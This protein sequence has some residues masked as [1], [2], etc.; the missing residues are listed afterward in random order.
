MSG[1]EVIGSISAVITL[2]EASIKIYDSAQNDIKL[3]KTFKVVGRRLPVILHILQ[4][5]KK[6]L[7]PGNDS[8]PPDVCNALDDILAACDEKAKKL[9]E[10]FEKVIPGEKDAWDK[11][12]AKVF[13]RVGKGNEVEEL[14]STLTEDVQLI[15]NNHALTLFM[16]TPE[17]KEDFSFHGP[18]G[19]CLGQAPY[20]TAEH[21]VGRRHELDEIAKVLSPKYKPQKQQRVI[22]GGMG[23]V[24]KTQLAIAYAESRPGSYSSVFWLDAASEAA[25]KD[26]FRSLAN[27]IFDIRNLDVLEDKEIVRRIHKWLSDPNNTGW[28]LIFD[29]YDEPSLFEIEK[30]YPPTSHGAIVVTTRRPDI[31][32]GSTLHIKPFQKIEDSLAILQTRSKRENVQLDPHAKRLAE[33]L[34]GLPLAL[35]TVGTFLRR[36]TFTFERYLQEYENDWNVDPHRPIKLQDY[37]ER[38]LYT[39]WNLSYA[40]LKIDDP[41]AAKLP[42]LLAYFGNQSF[43]YELFHAGITATSPEWLRELVTDYTDFDGAMR[44]LTEY[45]FLDFHQT[46][47]SWNMHNCVHDWTLA[48]LNEEID[49]ENY[50]YAFDCV[51][52]V[53]NGASRDALRH[54]SYSRLAR[55]AAQLVQQ[56]FLQCD[57]I[58]TSAP[59]QFEKVSRVSRLLQEQFQLVSAKQILYKRLGEL[60]KA[61]QMY[62]RALTGRKKALGTDDLFTLGVTSDLGALY[63]YQ[64]KLDMAEQMYTH[65]LDGMENMLELDNQLLFSTLSELAVLYRDQD[66]LDKAEQTYIRALAGMESV[67]EPDSQ[68]VFV[69]LNNFGALYYRQDKLDE[70]E[71]T[72]VRALAGMEKMLGPDH[73]F[74]LTTV[75]NL[76]IVYQRQHKLDKAEEMHMRALVG[77]EK[78]LGRDDIT[79]LNTVNNLGDI[80]RD[81]GKLNKSEQMYLRAR[82]GN[83]H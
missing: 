55:H 33:R 47:G 61:E 79:T 71:Q 42:K 77:R 34:A 62:T 32:A 6:D 29:N 31:V 8:M 40:R 43:W 16:V 41:D 28:L 69:T 76:G 24:G 45:D 30:Y 12:Y 13:R 83:E 74:T 5:C 19:A 54:T 22:L 75:S 20:I 53:I 3:T 60:N 38:T 1:L 59:D 14:M 65:T 57:I 46:L 2:L 35:A 56:R 64:G 23:G 39:T 48:A 68:L 78:T 49:T 82:Q 50:W 72:Y 51:D 21:F 81:Q 70:A 4:K 37:Q 44:I 67:L 10:I 80:W 27:F 17:K 11:R 73:I 18:L 63:R 36:S 58:S 52:A 26:S 15:V 25:L 7:E 66:R 9:R